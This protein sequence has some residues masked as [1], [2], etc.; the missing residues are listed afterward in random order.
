MKDKREIKGTKDSINFSKGSVVLLLLRR[1]L[2]IDID[3]FIIL[4]NETFLQDV[5]ERP[6]HQVH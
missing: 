5:Y 2:S 6:L 3:T 4:R 1:Q